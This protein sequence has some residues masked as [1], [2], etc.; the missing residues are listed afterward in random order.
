MSASYLVGQGGDVALLGVGWQTVD[1]V[2]G[3]F[4]YRGGRM[5][6]P[7][8]L[9]LGGPF[10]AVRAVEGLRGFVGV[11]FID[12]GDGGSPIVLEINPRLTTSFVGLR[13]LYPPGAIARAWLR[14]AAGEPFADDL[15]RAAP[16]PS[17]PVLRFS[18]DGTVE[19]TRADA[20]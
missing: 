18:A 17:R 13:R 3:R 20:P 9:G 19:T 5:P 11:D 1:V 4:H 8:G 15:E 6:A 14:A 12:P 2:R 16:D 10:D 7:R